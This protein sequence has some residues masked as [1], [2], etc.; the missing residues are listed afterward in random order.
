MFK[1]NLLFLV[2]LPVLTIATSPAH[3]Q[4]STS[5]LSDPFLKDQFFKVHTNCSACRT[6]LDFAVYGAGVLLHTPLSLKG[7]RKIRVTNPNT[8]RT[9]EV[10]YSLDLKLTLIGVLNLEVEI[11]AVVTQGYGGPKVAVLE[12]FEIE[13]STLGK[14][15][16]DFARQ[17]LNSADPSNPLV[18]TSTG[19]TN[20]A[21]ASGGLGGSTSAG[22]HGVSTSGVNSGWS[23]GGSSGGSSGGPGRWIFR[24]KAD[25]ECLGTG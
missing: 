7:P 22:A 17:Q 10:E 8:N 23:N 3:A 12:D 5:P 6:T 24:C 1:R 15:Y 25:V 18:S 11:D 14:V 2:L 13:W 21:S 16:Q 19:T 20:A 4:T 9:A